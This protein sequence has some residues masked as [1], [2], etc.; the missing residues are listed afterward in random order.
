MGIL[1]Q[2]EIGFGTIETK[3]AER[4]SE[5]VVGFGESLAGERKLGAEI[6]PHADVL[7]PL[8]WENEG[9]MTNRHPASVPVDCSRL[10]SC[11]LRIRF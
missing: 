3:F 7:R 8:T 6:L 4:K 10:P 2:L 9:E 5:R 1:G 11:R